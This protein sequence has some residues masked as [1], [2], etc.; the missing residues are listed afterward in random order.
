M[1]DELRYLR[2]M[3]HEPWGQLLSREAIL[4][5]AVT[6]YHHAMRSERRRSAAIPR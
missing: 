5:V 1:L 4:E 3:E 2:A 6:A